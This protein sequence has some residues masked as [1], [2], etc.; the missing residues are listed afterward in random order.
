[1]QKRNNSLALDSSPPSSLDSPPAPVRTRIMSS[2]KSMI[3]TDDT[4][5]RRILI[6]DKITTQQK[7]QEALPRKKKFADSSHV[8]FYLPD[9]GSYPKHVTTYLP[10]S[11]SGFIIKPPVLDSIKTKK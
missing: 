6:H 11:K 3:L 5:T 4:L 9:T 8:S 10:G 2:S 1:M 7:N